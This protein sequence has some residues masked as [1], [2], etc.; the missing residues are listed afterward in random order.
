MKAVPKYALGMY[1]FLRDAITR[2][3]GSDP[4]GRRPTVVYL[5]A[6][7]IQELADDRRTSAHL[8][9]PL[10]ARKFMGVEVRVLTGA[11]APRLVCPAGIVVL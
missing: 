3:I 11:G 10:L 5:P 6:A 1:D 8:D 9:D 4:E 2:A 7:A